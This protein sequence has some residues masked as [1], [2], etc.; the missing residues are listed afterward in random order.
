MY[1]CDFE[2]V[3]KSFTDYWAM[4]N[5]DRPIVELSL[6]KEKTRQMAQASSK[7]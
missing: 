1:N 2:K 5:H 4:E 3:K 7:G 6:D